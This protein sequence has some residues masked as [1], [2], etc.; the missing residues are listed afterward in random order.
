[1]NNLIPFVRYRPHPISHSEIHQSLYDLP[2][3]GLIVFE[4]LVVCLVNRSR[5]CYLWVEMSG[6][7]RLNDNIFPQ[8]ILII[9][10]YYKLYIC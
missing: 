5:G 8:K 1:M 9:I 4:V 10:K 3:S 7:G 6:E 2:S